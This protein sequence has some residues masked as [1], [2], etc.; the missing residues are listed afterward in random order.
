MRNDFNDVGRIHKER[1]LTY[2]PDAL[3]NMDGPLDR[4][5]ML[6]Q[7][8]SYFFNQ[9][10][11]GKNYCYARAQD[12]NLPVPIKE[13]TARMFY[14]DAGFNQPPNS[15]Q[16]MYTFEGDQTSPLEGMAPAPINRTDR[17]ASGA[18]NFEPPEKKHYCLLAV[19]S[20]EFFANNP[21][22]STGNWNSVT[23]ITYNGAAAWHN[24]NVTMGGTASLVF[25][26]QDATAERF[27][28]EA[29]CH[30]LPAGTVV[31]LAPAGPGLQAERREVRV[32][33]EFQLVETDEAVVPGGFAG[34]LAVSIDTP[35]GAPLPAHAVVELRMLWTLPVGHPNHAD[36]VA[37]TG[38]STDSPVRVQLGHYTFIGSES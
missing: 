12:V 34:Q 20:T 13:A 3:C 19:A 14:T 23:W 26:N 37:E 4:A 36:A 6:R 7:W 27:S 2:S 30:R 29:H 38:A 18:F 31:S 17:V 32:D 28:F 33:R 8:N 1:V 21:M 24:I 35:D 9:A 5:E 25:H 16:V 11:V 22:E 15:W 10:V